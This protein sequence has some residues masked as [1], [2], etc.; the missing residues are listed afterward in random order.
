[1]YR[2]I[3]TKRLVLRPLCLEDL[4]TVHEYASDKEN[5]KY[6][7]YLPNETLEETQ[8]FL[9]EVCSEWQKDVPSFYEFAITLDKKLIGAVCIYLDSER[10]EGELGWI[11]NKKYWNHGYA[12]EA[13]MAMKEFALNELK[14]SRL[15]AHCDSRNI[16]SYHIMEKIGLTLESEDGI[17]FN[18]NCLVSSKDLMYTLEKK[19]SI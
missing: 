16:S 6:M 4:H 1:M 12:T 2:E 14:V 5:A 15:I 19:D 9:L 7:V 11:L 17:R 13:A 3:K 10:R 18:K 8:E